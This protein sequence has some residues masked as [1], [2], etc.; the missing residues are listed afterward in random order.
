LAA[1][2]LPA[3]SNMALAMATLA[4]VSQRVTCSVPERQLVTDAVVASVVDLHVPSRLGDMQGR[5]TQ[6]ASSLEAVRGTV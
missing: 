1:E 3:A 4:P 6:S 5:L 2:Q